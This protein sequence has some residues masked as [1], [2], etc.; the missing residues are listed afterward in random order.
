MITNTYV[1]KINK[2][3]SYTWIY[4]QAQFLSYKERKK[5]NGELVDRGIN[6]R[7]VTTNFLQ[8]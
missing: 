4:S 2:N 5:I 7:L 6:I 1:G 8:Q 3:E